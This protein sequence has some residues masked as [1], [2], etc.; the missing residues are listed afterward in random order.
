M[1][2]KKIEIKRIDNAISRHVTF[3][4]RK[5][6]LFK[7]AEELSVLCDADVGLIIFSSTGKSFQYSNSILGRYSL[8][9]T[10][11]EISFGL[12]QVVE[13]INCAKVNKEVAEKTPQLRQLRGEELH[14]LS[15]KELHHLEM[16]IEA[17]L[18]CVIAKKDEVIMKETIRLQEKEIGLME[19]NIQLRQKLVEMANARKQMNTNTEKVIDEE[20]R[21]S[22]SDANNRNFLALLEDHESSSPSLKLGFELLYQ[23]AALKTLIENVHAACIMH[24]YEKFSIPG[25]HRPW[26]VTR[27]SV[28]SLCCSSSLYAF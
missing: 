16:S 8:H 27:W 2:R 15:I 14:L 17:Q 21:S 11:L 3:S 5:K 26:A 12:Q 28:P 19:E 1:A 20:E 6:G 24:G 9:R 23:L 4:K 13:D 7:K 10:N 18:L 22:G 25:C